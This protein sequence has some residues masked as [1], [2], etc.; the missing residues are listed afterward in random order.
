MRD[1]LFVATQ[2]ILPHHLISRAVYAMTRW[3]TPLVEPAIRA[4]SKHFGVNLDEALDSDPAGYRTF[5]AFF[6]RAL[7]PGARP[8]IAGDALAACP[9]DGAISQLG[10]IED[11]RIFQAKGHE[12]SLIE[13][14]GGDLTRAEP[15]RNGSFATIY[16]SPR[17]YHRIH[18]PL[19][20][21]LREMVHVPGRL[22]S[23]NPVTV[24]RVPRLFAR[25]ER[26]SALFDTQEGPMGMVLVG[27]MNVAAIETVWSGLVTP[28]RG[29][30][31]GVWKYGHQVQVRLE[32]GDE[33]G[34][35]NMGSTVIM[36]FPEGFG[37]RP[38]L[39]PGMPV[40]M[41]EAL[42]QRNHWEET[43]HQ[44]SAGEVVQGE[45]ESLQRAAPQPG[46]TD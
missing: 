44:T 43:A 35:F 22:F 34:R 28:P 13:L 14:L 16:L 36:L 3:R 30:E 18:M 41:G 21:T 29:R 26:V 1:A 2:Y 5:N 25:N 39:K 45:P 32:R 40:N 27:A 7:K 6:T 9:V 17:D 19:A 31:I 24:E 10:R 20:G 38:D 37:F 4:F 11:G 23:V 46:S 8:L 12:Y 33:M 42:A 15:F